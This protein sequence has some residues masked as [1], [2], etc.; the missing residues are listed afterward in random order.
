MSGKVILYGAGKEGQRLLRR[1][2]KLREPPEILGFAD[3]FQTK[4]GCEYPLLPPETVMEA[5]ADII[6]TVKNHMVMKEIY[7]SLTQQHVKGSIYWHYDNRL[8]PCT[9]SYRGF[10]R[11]ECIYLRDSVREKG[12]LPRV[13]MHVC[14]YCNLNCSGCSH[15]SPIFEHR[16]P[17]REK[18]IADVR[19]L[20]EKTG[21]ILKFFIM[22]GEPFL[23]PEI[24]RYMEDI[25]AVLPDTDLW[26]V[27][28][29]LLIPSIGEEV[30][31]C[32]RENGIAVSVSEYEPTHR[33][34]GKITDRIRNAGL[35][36]N[37]RPYDI[38]QKFI[39]P[40][41]LSSDSKYHRRCIS[42]GCINI[43]D[44]KIARCPTLMYIDRFNEV[45]GTALPSDGIHDLADCP[46]GEEL[47]ALL[48]QE[49]PLCRHC[50]ENETEWS[51]CGRKALL[52]DFAVED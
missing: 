26:V 29:G 23:N 40:L 17:D 7:D 44:G 2:K 33:I 8:D 5:G 48:R 12:I 37:I 27:T 41:S 50:V 20:S 30:F 28:N 35:H 21:V 42:E 1:M 19:T 32:M 34:I 3:S 10:L 13:E 43:W 16:L 24:I 22:G 47:L 11:R 46:S 18:R 31:D 36:Y 45:F 39:R 14:D 9:A 38:K 15:F 51:Q 52:S 49:V 25:R 6:I 4:S